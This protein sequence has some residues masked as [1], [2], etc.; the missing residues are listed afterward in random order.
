MLCSTACLMASPPTL[1]TF[2]SF[3]LEDISGKI[4][5]ITFPSEKTIVLIRSD[6]SGAKEAEQWSSELTDQCGDLVKIQGIADVSGVPKTLRWLA[7]KFIKRQYGGKL[8]LDWE[9]T[10]APPGGSRKGKTQVLVI[11]R[12][13]VLQMH[14]QG[15]LEQGTLQEMIRL[16]HKLQA[17]QCSKKPSQTR[18]PHVDLFRKSSKLSFS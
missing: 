5:Q 14:T 9:H 10:S 17:N 12:T 6:K 13:G 1:D 18:D 7:R 3:E 16:I 2:V 8:L 15:P 11:D 4:R